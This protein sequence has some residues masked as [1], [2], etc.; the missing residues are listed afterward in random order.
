MFFFFYCGSIPKNTVKETFK[1]EIQ[2]PQS[3]AQPLC[4]SDA[5]GSLC[6]CPD[7]ICQVIL[8]VISELQYA[9][10]CD[11]PVVLGEESSPFMTFHFIS[12]A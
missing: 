10:T 11:G 9:L 3:H 6:A 1:E 12:R 5:S 4:P 7:E 2:S 8:D